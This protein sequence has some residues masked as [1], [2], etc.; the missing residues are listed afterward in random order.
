MGENTVMGWDLQKKL[1]EGSVRQKKKQQK[2]LENML[3][4][5][6]IG[7]HH[8]A[9]WWWYKL[10]ILT[11]TSGTPGSLSSRSKGQFSP[12]CL[13]PRWWG[14]AEILPVHLSSHLHVNREKVENK[15]DNLV[16]WLTNNNRVTTHEHTHPHTKLSWNTHQGKR[17]LR[18]SYLVLW[19]L[20][21]SAKSFNYACIQSL[22]TIYWTLEIQ[23]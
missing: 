21:S 14:T 3:G 9:A 22:Q 5:K 1:K 20:N 11:S 12:E 8:S 7:T 15:G 17:G 16:I 6:G 2:P 13:S 10:E 19:W 18:G 4:D 23:K